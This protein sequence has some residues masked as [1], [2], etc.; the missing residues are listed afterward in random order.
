ISGSVDTAIQLSSTTENQQYSFNNIWV[1]RFVVPKFLDDKIFDED[2]EFFVC[3]DGIFLNSQ[4]LRT[5]YSVDTNF[6]LFKALYRE[7]G[8]LFAN[9]I[10]GTF[11]GCLYHKMT[12]IFCLFTDHL[13]TKP[14]FYFFDMDTKF[15]IFGSELKS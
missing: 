10:R 2:E 11:S 3:T 12:D 4:K 9:E 15:F 14:I 8:S 6:D 13:G 5:I 1:K 7:K